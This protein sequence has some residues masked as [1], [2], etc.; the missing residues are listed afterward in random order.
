[1][2][3]RMML[4][5][6]VVRTVS[7]VHAAVPDRIVHGG[8]GY[9]HAGQELAHHDHSHEHSAHH[10]DESTHLIECAPMPAFAGRTACTTARRPATRPQK[11]INRLERTRRG[12]P[13]VAHGAAGLSQIVDRGAGA[14]CATL[15]DV[16]GPNAAVSRSDAAHAT[17]SRRDA[18]RAHGTASR[19]DAGRSPGTASSRDA[20]QTPASASSRDAGPAEPRAVPEGP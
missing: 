9:G 4:M 19:H 17:A 7:H 6:G 8:K 3:A 14:M 13:A 15:G 20:A 5:G 11:R 16:A 1:M 2:L 18:G 10:A 12:R